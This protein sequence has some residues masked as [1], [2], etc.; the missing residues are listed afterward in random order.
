MKR[1][2]K[3]SPRSEEVRA[4]LRKQGFRIY[5]TIQ[6]DLDRISF[7]TNGAGKALLLRETAHDL[8]WNGWDIYVQL[9]P[10][11]STAKTYAA[12]AEYAPKEED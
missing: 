7:W 5:W 8:Q 2:I 4:E 10:D 9:C 1:V 11:N 3:E 6:E 12:L